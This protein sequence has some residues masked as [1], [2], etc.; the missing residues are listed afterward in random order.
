MIPKGPQLGSRV[1]FV[2]IRVGGP[3]PNEVPPYEREDPSSAVT[4]LR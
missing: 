1:A 3:D 4:L 2:D